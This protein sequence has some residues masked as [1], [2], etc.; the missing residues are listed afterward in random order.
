MKMSDYFG[1]AENGKSALIHTR[2]NERDRYEKE[3]ILFQ[4]R[5]RNSLSTNLMIFSIACSVLIFGVF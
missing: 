3:H 5:K 4:F 2:K 1:N